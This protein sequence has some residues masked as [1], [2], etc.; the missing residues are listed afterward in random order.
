[1]VLSLALFLQCEEQG[2]INLNTTLEDDSSELLIECHPGVESLM[3]RS[4][5][6]RPTEADGKS[7]MNKAVTCG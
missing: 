7:P 3:L 1:M 6:L 5:T 4:S 2:S